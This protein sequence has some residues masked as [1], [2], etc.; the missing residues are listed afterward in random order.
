MIRRPTPA[1]IDLAHASAAT[2]GEP[3]GDVP[4]VDLPRR[5]GNDN[6]GAMPSFGLSAGG[7]SAALLPGEPPRRRRLGLAVALVLSAA[8]HAAAFVWLS[9]RLSAEG[10]EADA[11]GVSVEI[12]FDAP[13]ATASPAIAGNDGTAMADAETA[14]PV[15]PVVAEAVEPELSEA[16]AA[17]A[18]Q[19]A[20]P[21]EDASAIAP[22]AVAAVEAV[23]TDLAESVEQDV[24]EPVAADEAVAVE[25]FRAVAEVVS[26][27]TP[28]LAPSQPE[29]VPPVEARTVAPALAET[30]EAEEMEPAAPA[31]IPP[32]PDAARVALLA[33]PPAVEPEVPAFAPPT[34]DTA[35][36][37]LLAAPPVIEPAPD[38]PPGDAAEVVLPLTVDQV[39]EPRPETPAAETR[40]AET[41]TAGRETASP[42]RKKPRASA[43]ATAEP[44]ATKAPA[45]AD[46]TA[47]RK[48]A[49]EPRRKPTSAA[50]AGSQARAAAAPGAEAKYGRRLL[51]HVERYKRHPAGA[52]SA[53]IS[54]VTRLSITIDR[55][56]GLAGARVSA[57]SGHR[58]LDD[59]ALAAARRAAPYP[60]PPEGVGGRTFS[61]AVTLRF[62]R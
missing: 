6:A 22:D 1:W 9:D 47:T 53:G 18:A 27:E 10:M 25:E 52:L 58:I 28:A 17:E 45:R 33:A 38:R 34:P 21:P 43:V 26:A 13:A 7:R 51:S 30:V 62:T 36:V 57:G 40:A 11:E 29:T 37:A 39:P 35:T 61:F 16:A 41:R 15:E 19:P 55:T 4:A 48:P 12:V 23:E 31:F 8:I 5:G 42:V 60:R 56:G 50:S 14:E 3:A 46:G 44:R 49:V 32:P 2:K 54:G 59:E 24:A 20:E